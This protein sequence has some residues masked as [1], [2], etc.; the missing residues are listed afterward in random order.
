ML[1]I[2]IAKAPATIP[3]ITVTV[4]PSLLSVGTTPA[5]DFSTAACAGVGG[6]RSDF[7]F[8]TQPA[9]RNVISIIPPMGSR[10]T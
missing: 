3:L 5:N 8:T 2:A 6:Q 1:A 10:H 7:E 9:R 4:V